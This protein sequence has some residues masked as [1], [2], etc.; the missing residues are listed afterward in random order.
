MDGWCTLGQQGIGVHCWG[1]FSAIRFSS[2]T[3]APSGPEAVYPL[4]SRLVRFPFLALSDIAGFQAA[5]ITFV[6]VSVI[7]VVSPL[8]WAVR[9]TPWSAK[10]VVVTVAG[11]TT[12]PA[13]MLLDRGNILALAVPLMLLALLGLVRDSPWTVAVATIAASSI[14]PQFVLLGV[15]LLALRH[16]RAAIVTF[17]GTGAILVAP[18]FVLGD[19]WFTGVTEWLR[20]A[21]RWSTSQPL[22]ASWP[23]N[24]SLPHVL[25][26]LAHAGPWHSLPIVRT[27]VDRDY[28]VAS[29]AIGVVVV[30]AIAVSGRRLPPLASGVALLAI[31]CVGSP[32]TYAYYGV[33][34]LP[35]FAIVYRYGVEDWPRD[36]RLARTMPVL[37]AIPVVL[38]LSPLI[39]PFGGAL[40]SPTV[41]LL[42]LL[43]SG[44]WVIF[45]GALA[46][47]GIS[48]MRKDHWKSPTNASTEA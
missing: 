25:Y 43:S 24:I 29:A 40:T 12:A 14:K 34:T 20:G 7:C 19:R 28:L 15:G 46:I 4:A 47:W 13:I 9:R 27:L 30:A 2:F 21:S 11:I 35:V 18:Y 10:P 41:S 44:A 22:S 48:R 38:G 26:L 1:D 23:N 45:V 33:F 42:P 17:L 16:W 39:I 3:S 36:T 5:L 8:I 32:L 31:A 6:I 37:L